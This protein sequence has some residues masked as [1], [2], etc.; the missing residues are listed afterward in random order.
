MDADVYAA[1]LVINSKL[2]RIL[3]ILGEEVMPQL[4]ELEAE[5]GRVAAAA[6]VIIAKLQ[7]LYD[8]DPARVQ[9]AIDRIKAVA[10]K[11]ETAAPPTGP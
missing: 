7:Q 1:F 4:D 8:Q 11:L 3:N 10:D 2:N 5:I 6:D 9:A